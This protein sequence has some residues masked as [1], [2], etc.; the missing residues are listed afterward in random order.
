MQV[1]GR[2][3]EQLF[4]T[5]M[6]E[7]N[8]TVTDV[9][10]NPDYWSKDIDF[11]CSSPTT[12]LTRTFE[13]KYDG[14]IHNTGNLFIETGNPRSK[15][16]KGYYYFCKADYLAYGD[17]CEKFFYVIPFDNVKAVMNNNKRYRFIQT[18]DGAEGYLIPIFEFEYQIL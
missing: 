15:G 12:G 6:E 16:G 13:I 5:K 7:K 11:I 17:A 1:N 9:S 2:I 4:R 14:M 8:Y 10:N 18:A 3:G